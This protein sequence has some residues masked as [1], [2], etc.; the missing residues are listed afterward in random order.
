[1]EK[2]DDV[3]IPEDYEDN[4][5]PSSTSMHYFRASF[6][7]AC[8]DHDGFVTLEDLETSI[9]R[10]SF[11]EKPVPHYIAQKFRQIA[12][13][14]W[15]ELGSLMNDP[16]FESSFNSY[17][18]KNADFNTTKRLP[19]VFNSCWPPGVAMTIIS[20]IQII[21]FLVDEVNSTT[22]PMGKV[23]FYDPAHRYEF[24]RYL[25]YMF[26]HTRSV[27]CVLTLIIQMTWGTYFERVNGWRRTLV[28]YFG[29]AVSTS[30]GMSIAV[31]TFKLTE[32]T[33]I[34]LLFM[35]LNV[36]FPIMDWVTTRNRTVRFIFF[37][38][39]TGSSIAILIFSVSYSMHF[40]YLFGVVAGV[41]VSLVTPENLIVTKRQHTIWWIVGAI[42]MI[43]MLVFIFWN[44]FYTDYFPKQV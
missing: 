21:V 41:L 3:N 43:L 25:T 11:S 9:S 18:T 14:S 36:A 1:M 26:V 6:E 19:S 42:Y 27:A 37:T 44:I 29:A 28:Y 40:L 38:L 10:I 32:G 13:L 23:L 20:I 2:A 7:R 30:L 12:R 33:F 39:A 4:T 35:V 22:R 5:P 31:P 34:A 24:W 15:N 8:P 16:K 17:V